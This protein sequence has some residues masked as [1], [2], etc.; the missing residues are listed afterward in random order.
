MKKNK[1]IRLVIFPEILYFSSVVV[2]PAQSYD[3]PVVR[4]RHLKF[5]T[6]DP[7]ELA[8]MGPDKIGE[9]ET[10]GQYRPNPVSEQ[11]QFFQTA[12][13][14]AHMFKPHEPAHGDKFR[15]QS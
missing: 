6:N 15:P 10:S 3:H 13:K 14:V 8:T 9:I 7:A 5:K 12:L 2:T 4:S 11:A 1:I